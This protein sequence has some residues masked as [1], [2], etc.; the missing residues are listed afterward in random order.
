MKKA[1]KIACMAFATVAL[2]AACKNAPEATEDTLIDTTPIEEIIVEDTMPI[3]D[4]VAVVVEQPVKKATA[5]KAAK[6]D[7]AT[8]TIT[9]TEG[10]LSVRTTNAKDPKATGSIKLDTKAEEAQRIKIEK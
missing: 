10:G 3:E 8:V 4:T 5:K 1:T 6:K 9:K 2:M 7:D